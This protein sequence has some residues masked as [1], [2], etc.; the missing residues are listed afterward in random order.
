MPRVFRVGLGS[1][2]VAVAAACGS[3]GVG[4]DDS[5][6]ANTFCMTANTFFPA[7]RTVAANAAVTWTN[8]SSTVHNVTFD[9]PAAALPVVQGGGAGNFTAPVSSSNQRR[10]AAGSYPFHCTIHPATMSGTVVAQ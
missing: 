2:M 4:P 1:L 5:C 10:F 6:P 3:D 7:S 9:T 8:G